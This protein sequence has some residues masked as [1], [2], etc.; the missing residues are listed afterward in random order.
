M[1]LKAF[2]FNITGPFALPPN[3][4]ASIH[5]SFSIDSIDLDAIFQLFDSDLDLLMFY[6]DVIDELFAAPMPKLR[7]MG[8]RKKFRGFV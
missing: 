5:D 2:N 7:N 6:Q 4:K 1:S 3:V 8:G